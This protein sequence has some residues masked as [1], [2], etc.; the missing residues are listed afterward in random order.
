[1]SELTE[2]DKALIEELTERYIDKWKTAMKLKGKNV[3]EKGLEGYKKV[4]RL[5]AYI[6][7][8]GMKEKKRK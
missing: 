6:K 5:M 3:T 1:M 8:I 4:A 7:V 2:K